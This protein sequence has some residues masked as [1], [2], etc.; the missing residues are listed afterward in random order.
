VALSEND[1]ESELSYA[2]LHAV[3]A[4]AG[5]SCEAAGRHS[6]A[7]GVDAL[8]RV[9]ECLASDSV[10]RDFAVE[11][12]L[13]ATS[14]AATLQ[15]KGYPLALRIDHYD[16]LRRVDTPAPRLLVALF[17]PVLPH[18]WL[19]H[20]ED[21]LTL[22]RTAYWRSLRGAPESANRASQTVYLPATQALTP[23]S[24]RDLMT[25]LSR[26]EELTYDSDAVAR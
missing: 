19:H 25:R 15:D 1:I 18:G 11:V 21:G 3:A 2:F 6:D 9:R 5:F 23:T 12:Q 24:F 4:R 17:L 10:F 13:K 20:A 14:E 26:R 22:R 8:V 16:K 7:A